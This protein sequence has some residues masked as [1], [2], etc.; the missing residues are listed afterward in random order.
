MIYVTSVK[1]LNLNV[2]FLCKQL[3]VSEL[4]GNRLEVFGF[5][6]SLGGNVE[7]PFFSLT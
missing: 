3:G 7:N 1:T 4:L 6:V 5:L 2:N